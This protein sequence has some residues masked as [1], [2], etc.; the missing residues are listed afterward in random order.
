MSI[1]PL[2]LKIA[3]IKAVIVVPILAPSIKGAALRNVTIFF[4]TNGTTRDVVIVLDRMVAVVTRP[5]PKDF[6]LLL[7]KNFWTLFSESNPSKSVITF[8]KKSTE[9]NKRA[10]ER[11]IKMNPLL[12]NSMTYCDKKEGFMSNPEYS[13]VADP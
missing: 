10:K 7:N 12:I 13:C 9:P 3:A 2:E 5:H 8:L 1:A 4:A 6:N 11:T